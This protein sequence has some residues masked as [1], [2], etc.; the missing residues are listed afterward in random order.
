MRERFPTIF[1]VLAVLLVACSVLLTPTPAKADSSID[2]GKATVVMPAM[3][4]SPSGDVLSPIYNGGILEPALPSLVNT[5]GAF[6][7]AFL[8]F[9]TVLALLTAFLAPLVPFFRHIRDKFDVFDGTDQEEVATS[10][11]AHEVNQPLRHIEAKPAS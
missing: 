2:V 1:G 11:R 9:L 8:I 6:F 3:L 4:S 5:F 10:H 7:A